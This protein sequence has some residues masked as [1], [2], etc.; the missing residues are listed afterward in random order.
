MVSK[1][2]TQQDFVRIDLHIHTPASF[3]DY[4]GENNDD[5]YY[6]ILQNAQSKKIK[7]IAITD[8]NTIEGYKKINSLK[9]KL[10]LEQQSLSTITDSQQVNEKLSDI[11]AKLP[12]FEG[13]LILPG[14]EF[15]ARPGI[16]I[17]LIFNTSLS[18]QSIEQFLADAGYKPENLGKTEPPI[19][20]NWDVVTLLDKTKALD[21]IV[22]DAHTDSE[23]GIW[24]EL[25]GPTRI[26][27]LRSEQLSGICYNNETQRD[28]ITNL[29]STP[30]YKRTK[31]PAFLRFSDAHRSSDVGKVFS[32]AKL[33][34]LSFESLSKAFSNPLE[35]FS[36][37][38]PSTVKILNS[39]A[40]LS[41]SFG[42]TKLE[43]EDDILLFLKLAC[44]LNNS[45]A[46]YILIGLT[47][48]KTRVG[49]LPSANHTISSEISTILHK[50]LSHL[51]KLE[52]YFSLDIP[53]VQSYT[54]QNKRFIL[55][56]YFTKGT[57][58]V[59]IKDDPSI[60]S[61][62]KS[63]IVTL[64]A[65]EIESLVQENILKDV[66]INI[67]N[68]LQAVEN[69]CLQIKNLTVSLPVLRKFEMNS[70][71]IRATPVVPEAITL[72]DS[73][74]QRLLKFPHM[75]GC[76]RGNLFYIADI[77]PPRLERA[78][79][80]H[81][82][83]LWL[84]QHPVPKAKLKETIYMLAKGAIY[85]SKYDYPFYSSR[86]THPL[87]KLY[88]EPS[89]SIYGMRFLVAFLKSSFYL[90]YLLNRHGTTNC[91]DPKVFPTLRL[92]L[93]KLN[94]P[95]SRQQITLIND[96]FDHIIREERKFIAELNKAYITK[97][98]H[99]QVEFVNNY[100]ARI[101]DHF[102]AIN[103]AI[104]KLLRL[105]D[106]EIDVVEKN[107]TFNKI[108]LPTNTDPNIDALPLTS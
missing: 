57:S 90:W 34:D 86:S 22:L 35:S 49:I 95:D 71:K 33:E 74:R 99:V 18:L 105:S 73:Q 56:L 31:P 55:S 101:A 26:H 1:A 108:Y 9:N 80:R 78:Y 20:P 67:V 32:W 45:E 50:V 79:L 29:L 54:L 3:P 82:L 91:T 88:P 84:V 2:D 19:L 10:L 42:I 21:C 98:T 44:A 75:I 17:L 97:D 62:R 52:P 38:E 27:C 59:N 64:S 41:N 11:K 53:Q 46:G 6:S 81:T 107:L 58:L 92:P 68:R 94:R 25:K 61:I 48:N 43:S 89:T 77:T 12:L 63:K 28:K 106:N 5:E 39:L 15:T 37:E 65:S 100:N 102:Y 51:R 87:L 4:E 103:Q 69:H 83:P 23:K 70:F 40:Q 72:N 16:H 96:T 85:Y 93:V 47:E 13:T 66:Q 104:Y 30:Q 8:H 60:Y 76:A 14:V 24:H 36:T 7:I